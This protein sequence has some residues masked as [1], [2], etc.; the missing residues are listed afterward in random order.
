MADGY[1]LQGQL[2]QG[3]SGHNVK[4]VQYRLG[5]PQTGQ[6]DNNTKS[7]VMAFQ[8]LHGL[9]VD[10]IVGPATWRAM[11]PN[12]WTGAVTGVAGETRSVMTTAISVVI[13][14]I[15]GKFGVKLFKKVF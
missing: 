6:F 11:F 1:F 7:A 10:G 13:I 15:A 12:G 14:F 5:L 3:M 9:S 2:K 8:R 4:R